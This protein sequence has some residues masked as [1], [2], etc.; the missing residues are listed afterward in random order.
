MRVG[1]KKKA[2]AYDINPKLFNENK[3]RGI[4]SLKEKNS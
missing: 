4:P 3:T 2:K 1:K